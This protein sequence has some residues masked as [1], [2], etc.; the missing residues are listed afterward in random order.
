MGPQD[1]RVMAAL[2]ALKLQPEDYNTFRGLIVQAIEMNIHTLKLQNNDQMAVKSGTSMASP[3]EASK[4]ISKLVDYLSTNKLLESDA[5]GKP[6]YTPTDL[7]A[8]LKKD[9]IFVSTGQKSRL[10]YHSFAGLEKLLPPSEIETKF[11]EQLNTL[12]GDSK[13]Q[14][15]KIYKGNGSN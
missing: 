7:V 14:C 1:S 9:G 6:G 12:R 11:I 3:E 5:Y 2:E 4:A 8:A 15:L 10:Q 13:N